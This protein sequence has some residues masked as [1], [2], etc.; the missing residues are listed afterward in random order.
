MTAIWG[1]VICCALA[2]QVVYVEEDELEA[3]NPFLAAPDSDGES[4]DEE[5]E[6]DAGVDEDDDVDM[7]DL[8]DSD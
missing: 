7:D 1:C 4:S 2:S 8:D 5:D 3:E 6:S